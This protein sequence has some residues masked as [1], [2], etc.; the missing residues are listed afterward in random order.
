M[1]ITLTLN[2]FPV[3]KEFFK[4]RLSLGNY[5]KFNLN[6]ASSVCARAYIDQ[7]LTAS[8]KYFPVL[9]IFC[10]EA[11]LENMSKIILP[12]ISPLSLCDRA[13]AAVRFLGF[14]H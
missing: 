13:D 5:F 3:S 10:K 2:K 7:L 4:T 11:K 8:T 6:R 1:C 14:A 12:S 9:R